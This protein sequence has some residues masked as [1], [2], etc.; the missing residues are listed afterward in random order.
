VNTD[1]EPIVAVPAVGLAELRGRRVVVGV[2]GI[3]FRDGLR[4]DNSVI[5]SGRICVPVLTEQDFY[6]AELEQLEMFSTLVPINR[7]WVEQIA[8]A[9]P[10]A[11]ALDRPAVRLP[12]P[13]VSAQSVLG[14]RLI[15][16]VPDGYARDLRATTDIYV[17]DGRL[18]MRVCSEI[19]WYRWAL[20]GSVPS[21]LE[22]AADLLWRE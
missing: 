15:Q 3:G 11:S 8:T 13:V 12:V 7:V 21:T 19:E 16:A 17:R 9:Q 5:Q 20:H 1:P 22:I 18:V 10:D 2:P 4:A 6:R 14:S